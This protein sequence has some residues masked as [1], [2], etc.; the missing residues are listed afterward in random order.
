[1][2]RK[3]YIV[4]TEP[5]GDAL[6]AELVDALRS[7]QSD[8]S[9]LGV[10]GTQLERRGIAS[11]YDINDLAI[12]GLIEGLKAYKLV[13]ERVEETAQDIIKH[14]PDGVVLID[15]WGF[16]W[17]IGQRLAE[18]GYKGKRIKLVGPQVWATRPSRAKTLAANVDHLLCIHAFEQPF[19]EPYGLS[20]TVI[21][22]S[23]LVQI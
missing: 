13:K 15:S 10:G 4:A 11:L 9:I 21:G 23:C 22:K 6:G 20:T 16:M 2:S 5:S 3:L 14:N 18:L 12:L 1:M 7:R 8:I 17:R 19:Y